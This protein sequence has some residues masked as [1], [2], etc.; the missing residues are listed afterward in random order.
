MLFVKVKWGP[1]WRRYENRT[2][3]AL[4]G[5]CV[6][7]ALLF[8]GSQV[9]F[10]SHPVRGREPIPA[11]VLIIGGAAMLFF[12][13]L[14]LCTVRDITIDVH[15]GVL[16][17]TKGLR[18]APKRVEVPLT[19]IVAVMCWS[20]FLPHGTRV[21]KVGLHAD[22]PADGRGRIELNTYDTRQAASTEGA[23]LQALLGKPLELPQE[24]AWQA[25][26]DA[27]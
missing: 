1:G 12:A 15:R 27:S 18:F 16:T 21:Y 8:W 4:V 22:P 3:Y 9:Y 20:D 10:L 5:L 6:F 25:I 14:G 24:A 19:S 2:G 7:I 13:L 17:K 26:A 11:P 23:V